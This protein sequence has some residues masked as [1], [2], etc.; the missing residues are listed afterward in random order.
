METIVSARLRRPASLHSKTDET[1]GVKRKVVNR[2]LLLGMAPCCGLE[3]PDAAS[4][5]VKR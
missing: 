3:R 4:L 2:R 5:M 1:Q